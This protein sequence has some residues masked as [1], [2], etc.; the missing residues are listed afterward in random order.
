MID[1]ARKQPADLAASIQDLM[2]KA[3]GTGSSSSGAGAHRSSTATHGSSSS[4]SGVKVLD[5][6]KVQLNNK[7]LQVNARV[8]PGPWLRYQTGQAG[9]ETAGAFSPGTSGQWNMNRFKFSSERKPSWAA[10]RP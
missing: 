7:M 5:G 10:G 4:S 2:T 9:R 6:M 1:G 8:L 3:T